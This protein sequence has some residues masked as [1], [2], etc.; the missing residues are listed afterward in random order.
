M[1]TGK[2]VI[3]DSKPVLAVDLDEC[4]GFFVKAIVKWHNRIYGS[5][6]NVGMFSTFRFCDVWGG[7]DQEVTIKVRKFFESDD[8][9]NLEPVPGALQALSELKEHFEIY[10]VTARQTCL[11]KETRSW[12]LHHYP[13]IFRDVRFGNHWSDS[14]EKKAKSTICEEIGACVLIDDSPKHVE[15][16]ARILPLTILFNWNNEHKWSNMPAV[17]ERVVE[18]IDWADIKT[19]LLKQKED[20]RKFISPL[21]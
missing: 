3:S 11:E 1:S 15:D 5:D 20:L 19:L 13:G 14:G 8:F 2:K 21:A 17:P 16:C 9:L 10:I 6:H 4:V 7:S 12:L 18:A